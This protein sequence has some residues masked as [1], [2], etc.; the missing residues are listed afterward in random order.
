MQSDREP[1]ITLWQAVLKDI[2]L[3]RDF[4]DS[5]WGCQRHLS[6]E[7]WMTI[8]GEE[9]GEACKEV[10]EVNEKK[11]YK[12]L[13]QVAAVSIAILEAIRSNNVE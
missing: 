12:E 4:Q 9:Y 6:L 1:D 8:L 2:S 10:L 5:K 7:T 13:V 11:L 3:E